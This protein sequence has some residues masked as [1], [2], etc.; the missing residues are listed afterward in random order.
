MGIELTYSGDTYTAVR[1]DGAKMAVALH[2]AEM[3]TKDNEYNI[4]E[5]YL[6]NDTVLMIPLEAVKKAFGVKA[7]LD[8]NG[9]VEFDDAYNAPEYSEISLD[10]MTFTTG[11]NSISYELNLPETADIKVMYKVTS[12]ISSDCDAEE[13]LY[14]H[15][16]PTPIYKDG[17]WRGAFSTA[18]S[19]K[20]Y[21][22]KVIA[23]GKV[24]LK[25]RAATTK[26]TNK[27]S[28]SDYVAAENDGLNLNPTYESLSY[29]YE[30]N[31]Y[32]CNVYFKEV[33]ESEWKKAYKPYKDTNADVSQFR[34]SIVNLKSNTEYQVKAEELDESG[35]V[36][37]SCEKTVVTQ[38]ENPPISQT[39]NLS[40]IYNG[41]SL[42][43][44]DLNGSE[45]GWIKIVGSDEL[46][47]VADGNIR[48]AVLFDNSSY[49]I[50]ENVTVK[51]GAKNGINMTESCNNIRIVNCDISNWGRKGLFCE[52]EGVYRIDGDTP[53]WDAAIRLLYVNS[54]T[55]ERCYIHDPRGT[56][57]FWDG[58][59]YTSVHPCGMCGIYARDCDGTVIRYNDFVGN[60]EHMFNDAIESAGNG[61]IGGGIGKNA[62]IYGNYFANGADDATELDGSQMN[63]RYFNNRIENFLCG[64]STSANTVGASY[65]YGNQICNLKY[66]NVTF[67]GG[68]KAGGHGESPY[69]GKLYVFN[70]TIENYGY[71]LSGV[72]YGGSSEYHIESRNNIYVSNG[73]RAVQFG[74]YGNEND[75]IDYDLIWRDTSIA[76]E[77]HGKHTVYAKPVYVDAKHGNMRLAANSTGKTMGISLDNFGGGS[78]VGVYGNSDISFMPQ[79]PIK[80]VADKYRISLNDNETVTVSVIFENADDAENIKIDTTGAWIKLVDIETSNDG[81]TLS[82]Q[83]GA[84]SA[85][86][87]NSEC[88][89]AV[90]FRTEDGCSIPIW[91][92]K[93]ME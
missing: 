54:V 27:Y 93:D 86:C 31:A 20:W 13:S 77:V 38:N 71:G 9:Y 25:E 37:N 18:F 64:V 62:D 73:K 60:D 28:Y 32:D 1:D 83:I 88:F 48:D 43:I 79:R 11:H 92:G 40:D 4:S 56:T 46:P 75:S 16:A 44:T 70:N 65:I 24:Y 58:D 67:G 6:Y 69:A 7:E 89:G 68:I 63:V 82:V 45:D 17:K 8:G 59:S 55:V 5:P 30:S 14:Y 49:I 35:N 66:F 21:G 51:G 81:K 36:I 34:G 47:I 39:I 29:Y 87:K 50:F 84:D 91:V 61:D 41:G 78:E 80:A 72:G 42:L 74:N 53:N 85:L 19:N 23:D 52:N 22:V 2:S 15:S 90:M 57:N 76:E 33:G 3:T 26:A 12:P 10:M